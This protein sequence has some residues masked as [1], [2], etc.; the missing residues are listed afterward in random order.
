[1]GRAIAQAVE[2]GEKVQAICA[3]FD[4]VTGRVAVM[5][6]GTPVGPIHPEMRDLAQRLGGLGS[7]VAY[8]NSAGVTSYIK[9]GNCAEFNAAN[10][11]LLLRN[12]ATLADIGFTNTYMFKANLARGAPIEPYAGWVVRLPCVVC[13]QMFGLPGGARS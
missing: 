7:R 5:Q 9:V 12:N 3:A 2:K 6:C 8:V 11:L 13:Q 4:R 1:L 10:R